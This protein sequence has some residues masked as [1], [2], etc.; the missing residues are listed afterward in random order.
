MRKMR[1]LAK[2]RN[3]SNS[4]NNN[5]SDSLLAESAPRDR[6]LLLMGNLDYGY[7]TGDSGE[8]CCALRF[9]SVAGPRAAPTAAGQGADFRVATAGS[10]DQARFTATG[11]SCSPA[12]T[13]AAAATCCSWAKPVATPAAALWSCNCPPNCCTGSKG[14]LSQACSRRPSS[15]YTPFAVSL[16]SCVLSRRIA[17]CAPSWRVWSMRLQC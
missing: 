14:Y 10:S 9:G 7:P 17:P 6:L 15:N 4:N 2:Q 3:Q 13:P 5:A 11:T 12:P 8:N 1:S 16:A